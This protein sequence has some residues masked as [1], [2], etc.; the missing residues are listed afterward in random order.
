MKIINA[1]ACAALLCGNLM[2]AETA[3]KI[4]VEKAKEI[5]GPCAA[6]HGEFGAGG[7]KGEY[8]R[9]AGQ[10]ARYLYEQLKNFQTQHRVNIPMIPYTKERELPE[11]D[12]RLISDWLATVQLSTKMPEFKGD[13]DALTRLNMVEKVMIIPRVVGDIQK[14][15]VVYQEKCGSCHGRQGMG[16][17]LFPM[18]TGQNTNY[19]K[20]QID[21]YLRGERPH[22]DEDPQVTVLKEIS[23][24]DIQNILAYLTTLQP[25][26]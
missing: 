2:A 12:M 23:A 7:K 22:E 18:L 3:A 15:G 1:L 11:E 10:H 5:Y 9:V 20:K 14:G 24:D 21:I 13:E 8:P 17:G 4:D 25:T 19:L 16:R 6:C 26:E